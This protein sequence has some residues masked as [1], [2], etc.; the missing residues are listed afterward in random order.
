MKCLA[1]KNDTMI[2]SK[3]TYFAYFMNSNLFMHLITP[4]LCIISFI[5]F[6]PAKLSFV[7]SFTGICPMI[8]YAFYYIPNRDP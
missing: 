8:L 1:C 3:T 2:D 6:E 5:F 7:E 4:L